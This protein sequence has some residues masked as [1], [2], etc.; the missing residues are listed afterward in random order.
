M[1]NNFAEEVKFKLTDELREIAVNFNLYRGALVSA[2]RQ[3]LANRGIE[4]TDEEKLKIEQKKEQRRNDAIKSK[5]SNKTWGVFDVSWKQGIVTDIDAPL[6]YSRQVINI[7]SILFSVMFGG[8]LLAIN[9]KSVNNKKA[10]LP[11]LIYSILYTGIIIYILNLIPGS[12][13]G[14]SLIFNLVGAIVLYNFFWGK[15]IGKDF[16]YR[17]KQIWIPLIIGI[18]ISGFF[19]WAL[20][21]G[22]EI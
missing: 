9:L 5:E 4:L 12:K 17:T 6:L 2:A 20:I 19:I 13:S 10:I 3:E 1:D 8:I 16:K 21:V 22:S 14:L 11:V 15:Y 18:L 7:F